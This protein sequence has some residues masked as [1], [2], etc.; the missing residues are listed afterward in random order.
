MI[1]KL[2]KQ[3]LCQFIEEQFRNSQSSHDGLHIIKMV[4]LC[5]ILK[6]KD[7]YR[8]D[9]KTNPIALHPEL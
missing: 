7:I 9:L 5:S 8:D 2:K 1:I 6:K 4:L 3:Y